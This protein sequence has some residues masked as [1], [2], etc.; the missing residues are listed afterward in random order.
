MSIDIRASAKT[1]LLLALAACAGTRAAAGDYPPSF[2]LNYKRVTTSEIRD[3]VTA[4]DALMKLRP[5]LSGW[6][7]TLLIQGPVYLDDWRIV[8]AQLRTVP[9]AAIWEI[10][11]LDAVQATSR[12][13]T[14]LPLG[15]IAVVTRKKR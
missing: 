9:E 12:Y 15:A 5:F 2:P 14:E 7:A 4:Y 10:R 8:P 1:L 13:R 3:V 6:R 11:F